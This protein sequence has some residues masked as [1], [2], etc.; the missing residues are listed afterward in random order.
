VNTSHALETAR[1]RDICNA[2]ERQT[3]ARLSV[4]SMPRFKTKVCTSRQLY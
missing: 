2:R 3:T 4:R 1:N